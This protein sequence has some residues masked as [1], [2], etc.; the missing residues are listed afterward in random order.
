MRNLKTTK[1]ITIR[2]QY[3]AKRGHE[4]VFEMAVSSGI[5]RTHLFNYSD[6]DIMSAIFNEQSA[7]HIRCEPKVFTKL[8]DHFYHSP[9]VSIEA[10]PSSFEVKSF[11]HDHPMDSSS[12]SSRGINSMKHMTTGLAINIDE[13]EEYE[14]QDVINDDDGDEMREQNRSEEL[15]ICSKEVSAIST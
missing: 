11:H 2:A 3:S 8:L 14:F 9:E 6:C 13:F 5:T 1:S 10:S 15:V 4:L 7:S 12:A